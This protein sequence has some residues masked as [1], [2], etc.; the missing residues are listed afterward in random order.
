MSLQQEIFALDETLDVLLN[1]RKSIMDMIGS[2]RGVLNKSEDETRVLHHMREIITL[3]ELMQTPKYQAI[4]CTSKGISPQQIPA[5]LENNIVPDLPYLEI[6]KT[7]MS[8]NPFDFLNVY[9]SVCTQVA[10]ETYAAI[11]ILEILPGRAEGLA[12]SLPKKC[13]TE[14]NHGGVIINVAVE[15][16]YTIRFEFSAPQTHNGLL[17]LKSLSIHE[18]SRIPAALNNP[19]FKIAMHVSH[20]TH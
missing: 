2:T 7:I 6:T 1:L 4:L 18:G 11:P 20:F 15:Q 8:K 5:P 17:P 16:Y 10:I 13:S 14:H 19:L 12:Q 3:T 9:D